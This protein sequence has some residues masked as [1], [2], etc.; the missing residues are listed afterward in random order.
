MEVMCPSDWLSA[1]SSF[2]NTVHL[3]FRLPFASET[4]GVV[5]PRKYFLLDARSS[6]SAISAGLITECCGNRCIIFVLEILVGLLSSSNVALL[7]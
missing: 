7:L 1:E 2:L 3:C 5:W 4:Y 6:S